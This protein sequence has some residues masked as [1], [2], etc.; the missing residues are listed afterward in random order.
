MA[1]LRALAGLAMALGACGGPTAAPPQAVGAGP[2]EGGCERR[3]TVVNRAPITLAEFY[4]RPAGTT[5]WG[6]DRFGT[7]QLTTN[8]ALSFRHVGA[9]GHD[10]RAVW[11]NNREARLDGVN[12]CETGLIVADE[13]GLSRR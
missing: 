12:L 1:V 3:I 11:T 4:L 8:Q 6:T 9:A 13:R 2:P 7:R 10:L 5:D